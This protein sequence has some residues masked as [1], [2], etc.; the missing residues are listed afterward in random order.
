MNNIETMK[1]ALEALDSDNPD[2]QLRAAIALRQAIEQAQQTEPVA[3][4]DSTIAGHIDW[5]CTFFPKQGTKLYTNPPPR[6]PL[7]DEQISLVR[8]MRDVQGYDGNWNYD[9]YM[10]GLYNGLEFAVSLLEKRE[11]VFRD[12]PEQWLGDISKKR[13]NFNIVGSKTAAHGIKGEA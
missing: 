9:P 2:I 3:I 13:D 4:V 5:L 1:L 11:P 6:Q 7:T 12:A 8:E 10:Q